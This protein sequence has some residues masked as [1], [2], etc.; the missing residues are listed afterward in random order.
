MR[1]HLKFVLVIFEGE[2]KFV[3]SGELSGDSN[4]NKLSKPNDILD[5]HFLEF[6]VG[7]ENSVMELI[8]KGLGKFL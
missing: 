5:F 4:G 1:S 2:N 6:K 7:I 8:L 3:P